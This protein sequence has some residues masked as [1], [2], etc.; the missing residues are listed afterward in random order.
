M[1]GASKFELLRVPGLGPVTVRR[2]L[3]RRKEGRIRRME[4][5]GKVGARLQKASKY[6]VF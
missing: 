6:V 4:D 3:R 5:V 1:N 2:I